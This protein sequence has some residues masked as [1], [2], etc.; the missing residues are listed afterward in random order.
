M[1]IWT[2]AHQSSWVR[3]VAVGLLSLMLILVALVVRHG[4]WER[5]REPAARER[6][7]LF[8]IVTLT[9]L[10]IGVVT[11]YVALFVLLAAAAAVIIPGPRRVDRGRLR[12]ALAS[13]GSTWRRPGWGTL[14]NLGARRLGPSRAER[15]PQRGADIVLDGVRIARAVDAP[16][17]PAFVVVGHQRLGVSVIHA[18]TLASRLLRV[19][20]APLMAIDDPPHH[21]VVGHVDEDC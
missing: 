7:V 15:S 3:L 1:N 13:A 6:L 17:Q 9:T 20:G 11:L 16:Q 14:I 4:L 21:L 12:D 18:E 5:A 2:V 10:A 8:N 19:V